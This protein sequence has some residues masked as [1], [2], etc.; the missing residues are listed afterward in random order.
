[1]KDDF[2]AFKLEALVRLK[3][4]ELKIDHAVEDRDEIRKDLIEYRHYMDKELDKLDAK[5]VYIEQT[6]PNAGTFKLV[7]TIIV[8]VCIAIIGIVLGFFR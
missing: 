8:G 1:M 4:I 3:E 5:C 7:T 6:T 2:N